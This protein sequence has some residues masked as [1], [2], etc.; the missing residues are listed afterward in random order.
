MCWLKDCNFLR[1]GL[2]LS[3][4]DFSGSWKNTTQFLCCWPWVILKIAYIVIVVLILLKVF[5]FFLA[6]EGRI[7]SLFHQQINSGHLRFSNQTDHKKTCFPSD[8]LNCKIKK[9]RDCRHIYIHIGLRNLCKYK[10][11]N[12]YLCGRLVTK[13]CLTVLRPHGV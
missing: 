7:K 3:M 12:R 10:C 11:I 8:F 2:F 1:V 9:K 4:E 13:S 5:F 6:G